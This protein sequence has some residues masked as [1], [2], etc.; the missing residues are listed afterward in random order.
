LSCRRIS[1]IGRSG[2]A[3]L[4]ALA[5]CLL[6]LPAVASAA[7]GGISGKVTFASGG[8]VAGAEV[9]AEE[10]GELDFG[11]TSSEADGDYE[12]TGLEPGNYLV[13]FGATES[14]PYVVFQRHVGDVAVASGATTAGIDAA[15]IKGGAIE[16]TVTDIKTGL[17]LAEVEVSA[18]WEEGNEF[19]GFYETGSDGKFKLIGLHP[20]P[21]EIEFWS[22]EGVYDT[23]FVNVTVGS[24]STLN[25]SAALVRL[26]GRVTGHV[27]AAA[28]NAPLQGVPV[29]AIWAKTGETGGCAVTNAAGAYGFFPISPGA[30]KIVFSPEP[31]QVEFNEFVK[32]DVWPTQFW[33]GK[34][35]LAEADALNVTATSIFTGIDGRL[36][37]GPKQPP[38]PASG[39]SGTST[40]TTSPTPVAVTPAPKPLTC[41]KGF[42]KKRVKGVQRCVKRHNHRH[43]KKH[44]AHR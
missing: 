26:E 17:P 29:C 16:G 20:G 14:S 39:N 32:S 25:A 13:S 24:G 31:G 10:E 5:F 11:C 28:T 38:P 37:A 36:G 9:C 1:T 34:S 3:A 30:W 6:A 42:V 8:N 4:V 43:H 2:F 27:Y 12:I 18:L 21:H 19:D 7:D 44:R 40:T 15:V 22:W 33:N 41:K 23:R 35:T